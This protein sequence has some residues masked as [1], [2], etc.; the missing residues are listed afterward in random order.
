VHL[1]SPNLLLQVVILVVNQVAWQ[2]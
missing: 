2:G 1:W